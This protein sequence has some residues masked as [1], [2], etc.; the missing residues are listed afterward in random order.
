MRFSKLSENQRFVIKYVLRGLLSLALV[1]VVWFIFKK[2]YFDHNSE[3]WI[4]KFYGNSLV[5]HLIYVAS[6]VFFG[7]LPPEIFMFWAI[8]AGDTLNYILNISFFAVVSL[9]AGHLT[10]WIGR[11]LSKV[12]GKRISNEKFVTKYLPVVNKFGSI[13]IVIAALTPL[14]WATITLIMGVLG[15]KYRRF[16]YF[17]F[18][19]ILRFAIN[20]FLIFQTGSIVF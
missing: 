14:P 3:Y 13:I 6:E 11:Y 7:I 17:S 5:I 12:F 16:T 10:Y 8:H 1:F 18:S 9:G 20:G 19:R 2:I 15:Y 4:D